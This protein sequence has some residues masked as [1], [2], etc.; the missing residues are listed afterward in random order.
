MRLQLSLRFRPV[1]M[2]RVQMDL[3]VVRVERARRLVLARINL[4][5]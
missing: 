3:L 5:R 2:T 4:L 1:V